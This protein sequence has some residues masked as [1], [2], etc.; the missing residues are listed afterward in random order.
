MLSGRTMLARLLQKGKSQTPNAF[1][2]VKYG[3]V[4]KAAVVMKSLL[5]DTS[6]I[7]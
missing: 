4:G 2:A 6:N 3:Y 7:G 1:N 5:S